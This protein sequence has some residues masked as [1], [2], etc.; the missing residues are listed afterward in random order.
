MN[1]CPWLDII[2]SLFVTLQLGGGA[3]LKDHICLYTQEVLLM[4]NSLNYR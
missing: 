4:Y 1:C 3:Y 2:Q